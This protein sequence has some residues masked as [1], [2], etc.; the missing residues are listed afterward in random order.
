MVKRSVS[1]LILLFLLFAVMAV[2]QRPT[3]TPQE[4]SIIKI[5]ADLITVL[6]SVTD[7]RGQLINSLGKDDFELIENS[8]TQEIV[9][10]GRENSLPLQLVLLFDVSSSVK[11]RLKFEQQAATKFFKDILRPIDRAALLSFSHDVMVEQ[12][13]TSN[14]EA[15][16][17][18]TRSLKAK[19]GTAL[20]DA[21]YLAA[22]RLEKGPGRHVIVIISDGA[23][24][25]SKT[26]LES[27]LRMT[28]RADA[29]IYGI[30]TA[31]RLL[32]ERDPYV[33]HGDQ[34]LQQIC[35][36]TG[37]EV[38][39]PNNIN[40]LNDIFAQ[41]AA[42]LRAQYALSYYSKNDQRDGTYRTLKINVKDANL[43][44]RT[45]KGYYAPKD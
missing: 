6:V 20:Y 4:E 33:I 15:L 19:G 29:A 43:K 12:D 30:Y 22:Q 26:T 31:T 44:V 9:T 5:R 11:P 36:R 37:G 27:A 41:L 1:P 35:E 2:A 32:D 25:I 3:S 39:F 7:Q 28:E 14:V 40:D 34:E 42:V 16:V 10:F 23:N 38:F 13:F 17:N 18:A 8:T 45:R 24:T 21:I